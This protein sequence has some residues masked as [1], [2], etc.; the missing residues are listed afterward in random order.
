M[1]GK[2]MKQLRRI[3]REEMT[4]GGKEVERNLVIT[5]IK[6]VH[7]NTTG[8]KLI[9]EPNSVRAMTR[10]MKK[11]LKKAVQKGSFYAAN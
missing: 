4:F 11:A 7:G 8:V 9:N 6:G 3:A 10:S 1:S 5:R 2:K